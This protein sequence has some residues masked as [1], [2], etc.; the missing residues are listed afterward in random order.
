MAKKAAKPKK[1]TKSKTAAKP[2]S[3]V[4]TRV[5][6]CGDNLEQLQKLPENCVDLIYIDPPFNSNRNYEVFWGETKEKR[7]SSKN[8]P[9]FLLY[10][11]HSQKIEILDILR[12]FK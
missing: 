4:D 7:L 6:Y 9:R 5:I 11:S 2:S 10:P 3:L 12:P 8:S 1:E